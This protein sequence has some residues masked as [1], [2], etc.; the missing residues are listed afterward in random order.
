[1][2][3]LAKFKAIQG[4]KDEG[5]V[6]AIRQTREEEIRHHD[7]YFRDWVD[8]NS[9]SSLMVAVEQIVN[10][11]VDSK[12]APMFQFEHAAAIIADVV[13][14]SLDADLLTEAK[15][16]F[17]DEVDL[18]IKKYRSKAHIKKS[19]WPT[20]REILNRGPLLDIPL[21]T[22]TRLGTGYLTASEVQKANDVVNNIDLEVGIGLNLTWPEEAQEAVESYR[23]WIRT[24]YTSGLAL[25]FHC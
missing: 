9:Y 16:A 2:L 23:G 21:D 12:L 13:G 6:N 8:G 19:I 5:L 24:A 4:S 14:H 15:E 18:M 22:R 3:D 11:R 10:G 20:L 1:M 7:D 17:W 25:F